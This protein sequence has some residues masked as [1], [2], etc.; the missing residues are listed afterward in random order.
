MS[1]RDV[2]GS[3]LAAVQT[4]DANNIYKDAAELRRQFAPALSKPAVIAYCGGGIAAT[5]DALV[6]AMLGYD[7]VKVYD[8]SLSEWAGDPALPMET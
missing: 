5:A 1:E 6:L 3:A 8:A 2:P 4:V 7:K